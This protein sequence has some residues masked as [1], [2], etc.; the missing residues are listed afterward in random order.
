MLRGFVFRSLFAD[1][2]GVEFSVK[3]LLQLMH[4]NKYITCQKVKFQE[5]REEKKRRLEQP[6]GSVTRVLNNH[7]WS[8]NYVT[9]KK[10]RECQTRKEK[11][12]QHARC[13]G[14]NGNVIGEQHPLSSLASLIGVFDQS[15]ITYESTQASATLSLSPLAKINRLSRS[16]ILSHPKTGIKKLIKSKMAHAGV[17]PGERSAHRGSSSQMA[18]VAEPS[19][20]ELADSAHENEK[21]E[22][23]VLLFFSS[24]YSSSSNE[25][26]LTEMTI[27]QDK[28][29]D[30]L[31]RLVTAVRGRDVIIEKLQ[32]DVKKNTRLCCCA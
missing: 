18:F 17:I 4:Q 12:M 21:E 16:P 2:V 25:L 26:E 14:A 27:L 7:I 32:A 6:R 15:R 13:D 22:R 19:S 5:A 24:K 23:A 1:D 11:G 9:P 30:K 29:Q 20:A 28:L 10:R 31:K 8:I 3:L